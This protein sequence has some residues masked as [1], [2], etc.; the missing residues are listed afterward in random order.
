DHRH[1]A[2]LLLSNVKSS[3]STIVSL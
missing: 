1:G 3:I 2:T